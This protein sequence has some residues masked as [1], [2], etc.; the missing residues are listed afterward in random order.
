MPERL[1]MALFQSAAKPSRLTSRTWAAL[2]RNLLHYYITRL[3]IGLDQSHP[4]KLRHA[5][6]RRRRW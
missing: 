6:F 5:G 4:S 1:G 2:N 3:R